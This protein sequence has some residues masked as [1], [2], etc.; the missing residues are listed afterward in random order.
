MQGISFISSPSPN[1]ARHTV[2]LRPLAG[3]SIQSSLLDV[4]I[5]SNKT[6]SVVTLQR[7]DVM[8]DRANNELLLHACVKQ[9]SC[10]I[11]KMTVQCTLHQGWKKSRFFLEKVIRF[12][13]FFLD[14]SVQIRLDTI[15]HPERT[16]YT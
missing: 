5:Q 8:I 13:R 2:H 15:F 6:Y 1:S 12:F 7:D 4:N 3:H 10:A 14:L 9:E 16:S 11:A